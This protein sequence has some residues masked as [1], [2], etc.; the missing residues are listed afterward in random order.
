M[1][2]AREYEHAAWAA[3]DVAYRQQ[4]AATGH[5]RW[6]EVNTL[7]Y[8]VCFMGRGKSAGHHMTDCPA[9]AEAEPCLADRIKLVKGTVLGSN[10]LTKSPEICNKFNMKNALI[11]CANINT[12]VAHVAGS[13]QP[14]T[15]HWPVNMD[16]IR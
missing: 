1:P 14:W 9:K 11:K 13:T 6:S 16:S 4:A 12:C 10:Q 2:T 8:A 3:Y 15:V 5:R 7:L